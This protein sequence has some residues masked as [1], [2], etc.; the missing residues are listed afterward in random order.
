MAFAAGV[1]ARW[2]RAVIWAMI[3]NGMG[4]TRVGGGSCFL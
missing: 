1:L 3:G 4:L 2:Q